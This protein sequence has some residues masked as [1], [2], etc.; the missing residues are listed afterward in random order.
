[1]HHIRVIPGPER[2]RTVV[3]LEQ[4]GFSSKITSERREQQVQLNESKQTVMMNNLCGKGRVRD[5]PH[6]AL[7]MVC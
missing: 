2:S 6:L 7:S 4:L 3:T 1:M 5:R